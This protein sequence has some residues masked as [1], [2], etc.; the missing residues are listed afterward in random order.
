M[1]SKTAGR[2]T[3]N[4]YDTET[5][6]D[7]IRKSLGI[8]PQHNMLFPELTVLQ[9]FILFGMVILYKYDISF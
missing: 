8:C 2:A 7:T 1:Y 6:M 3:M 5:N 9:H 4:G